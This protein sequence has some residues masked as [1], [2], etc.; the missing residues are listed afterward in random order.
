MQTKR[1]A[2]RIRRQI[3]R[4]SRTVPGDIIAPES[5]SAQRRMRLAERNH[6][7][8]ETKNVL[9]RLELAPV[10]PIDFVVLVVRIIVA[11]LCIQELIPGPEHRNAVRQQEQTAEV[12]NLFPA[13]RENLCWRVRVSFVATVPTVIL[14]R[15]ILVVMAVLPVAFLVVRNQ[16]VEREPVMG[17]NIV[18]SLIGMVSIGPAIG[19]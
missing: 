14:V 12:L 5:A 11:E 8:E 4:G 13:Q 1:Q 7:F 2:P 17:I 19:E 15:A 10:E 6:L 9:I 3:D 18:H 16:I